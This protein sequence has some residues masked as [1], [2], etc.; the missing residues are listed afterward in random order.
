MCKFDHIAL[1]PCPKLIK[2][3]EG[4]T[5]IFRTSISFIFAVF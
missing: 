3:C 5:N 4:R 2:I 1:V